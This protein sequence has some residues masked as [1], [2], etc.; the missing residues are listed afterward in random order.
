[1]SNEVRYLLNRVLL[2]LFIVPISPAFGIM[3]LQS[4]PGVI[5]EVVMPEALGAKA[6]LRVGDCIMTYDGRALASPAAL[7]ALEEN[8]F[9]KQEIVLQVRR[10]DERLMLK[11]PPGSLGTKVRPELPSA[12][13]QLYEKGRAAVEAQ[14][15]KEAIDWWEAATKSARESEGQAAAWIYGLLGEAYESQGQWQQV[16]EAYTAAWNIL[17]GSGDAA[18]QA[19]TLTALGRASQNLND[20]AA[21][22]RWFEQARKTNAGAG[23]EIWVAGNLNGLGNVAYDRGDLQAAHDYYFQAL[24]IGERLAPDSLDVAGSLH[25]LGLIARTRGD[26]PAAQDYNRRALVIR[27]RLVPD[28]L[29][30]ADSLN[31]LGNIVQER[32]D[33]QA[34]RDY[35]LKALT[36]SERLAPD[37]LDAGNSLNNL[38]ALEQMHGDLQAAQDYYRRAL[39]ISK[40]MAPDSL[41]VAASLN[42]LGA[43]AQMRGDLQTAQDYFS[44]ALAIQERLA[45]ESLDVAAGVDNLGTIAQMRGD[46]Q[47]AQDYY[48]RA[49]AMFTRLAPD[50]L[51]V[52]ASFNNLGAVAQMRGDLQTAQGYHHRALAI[53]ERLAPDSLDVAGSYDNL[54]IIAHRQ[55]DLQAA[56]DYHR[57]ALAIG[58]R[59]APRSLDLTKALTNLGSVAFSARRFSEARSL[60][61]RAVMIVEA[62]RRTITSTE[63]RSLLLAQYQKSYSGLLRTHLSLDDLP[64]AFATFERARARGL[65]D[66]LAE[67]RLDLRADAPADLL[68]QQDLLDHNRSTA[69]AALARL[70]PQTD[71]RRIDELRA[72]LTRYD[73]QQRELEAQFRRASPRF[74][75]LQYPEPLDLDAARAAL[76]E[77][78]LLLAYHVDEKQTYLFAVTRTGLKVLTLPIEEA[79]LTRQVNAFRDA[80]GQKRLG[81]PLRDGQQQGGK[82]YDDLVRPAQEWVS[83]A[84]RIL[85]CPDRVLHALP[86]AALVSRTDPQP[87]YFIE[88]KPL[89]TIVSMTV[90]AETRKPVVVGDRETPPTVLAFGDAIYVK[91][92]TVTATKQKPG[93]PI[94]KRATEGREDAGS[95][96]PLVADLRRRGWKWGPL[97]GTRKEVEA[98]ARLYG[99]AATVRIGREATKHQAQQESPN[100]RILHFAVHGW[101]DDQIGLNSG[102]AL[103]QPE[104]LG[105]QVEGGDNGLWQAWEIIGQI[106]VK[107]DLVV[108]SACLSGLGQEVRGEGIIGLTRAFQYA[109]ARS[110]VVSLWSVSDESTAALMSA[111]YSELR[112][113]EAKDVA[114]QKAMV[115]VRGNQKW[116]HP[117][118]WS[119]FILTGDY[120]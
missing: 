10:R 52:A 7:Q 13:L 16:I 35:Y 29:D 68:K 110:V 63:A 78:T 111:F 105:L 51:A 114:L 60:F 1:M 115:A 91:E 43:V 6:G 58:E 118:Y 69:Y 85:I 8:I 93:A 74:A 96:E 59:L 72:S 90:Y 117:Y 101:L 66:L 79:V 106:R 53:Q 94:L 119:A 40:R 31:S 73:I 30:V 9:G 20:I 4:H 65:V 19:R 22:E 55:G 107:A 64:A 108:L 113:G 38:G 61:D 11:T 39:A 33:L 80:V 42:N 49:L 34:A 99:S 21:A 15:P 36:I 95:H 25:N 92:Q 83:R 82:L 27:E 18:A 32:G 89:H 116:A 97:P 67:R 28:S 102:L 47:A 75:N 44:R 45:P 54:G 81:N 26:L 77:G 98:I 23:N 37:S 70:N 57:R 2:A 100:Y 50:S 76:D 3:Y 86:F 104:M 71:G 112:R 87:R 17:S 109:G 88:E 12:M 103:S 120:K 46:S 5:V 56:Q 62:Q 14:K 41:F 48:R 24:A 84:T